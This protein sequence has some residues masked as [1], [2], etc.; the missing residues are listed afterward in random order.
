MTS[1]NMAKSAAVVVSGCLLAVAIVTG[2]ARAEECGGKKK[3]STLNVRITSKPRTYRLGEQA[4]V[5][6]V[7]TRKVQGEEI[8]AEGIA[9][10]GRLSQGDVTSY[11]VDQTDSEGRAVARIE[12]EHFS[13][14]HIDAAADAWNPLAPD[15]PCFGEVGEGGTAFRLDLIRL[16]RN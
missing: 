9:V 12:L 13:V 10:T 5:R 3:L 14:G 1:T 8:P 7:V 15:L 16:V 2:P 6:I 11:G 4:K